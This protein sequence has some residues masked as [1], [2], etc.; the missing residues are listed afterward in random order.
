MKILN[1]FLVLSQLVG[2]AITAQAEKILVDGG[3]T[4][5]SSTNI[6]AY[7][8]SGGT[9][10][11]DGIFE[12]TVWPD[13]PDPPPLVGWQFIDSEVTC[14]FTT[15]VNIGSVVA[16]FADSDG[17]AGVSVPESIRLTTRGG[18]D[19][20]F[21]VVNPAGSGTTVPISIE[22]LDLTTDSITLFIALNTATDN[23]QCC[24]GSYEWIMMSE[25][26]FFTP[27]DPD[28]PLAILPAKV[29]V[30]I[31]NEPA[32]IIDRFTIENSSNV[33]ADLLIEGVTFTGPDGGR[34]AVTEFPSSLAP[35]A[36]GDV[37]FTV[38]TDGETG[39]FSA[40]AEIISNDPRS[41][42]SVGIEIVSREPDPTPTTPYQRAVVESGAILYWTFDEA[43]D[44][45][46][47]RSLVDNQIANEIVPQGSATRTD[48]TFT[49]GGVSLGR[50]ASFD[51]GAD[52]RFLAENLAR[53]APLGTYVIE[54][55]FIS[56]ITAD[57]YFSEMF[58][59]TNTPNQPGLIYNYNDGQLE[60]FNGSRTGA[61]ASPDT[62][63][64][65]VIAH[66]GPDDGVEI[67]LDNELQATLTET[68]AGSHAF[69]RF[70][71]GNTVQN[72]GGLVGAIDEYAI[73]DLDPLM[74]LEAKRAKVAEIAAHS[75]LAFKLEV[76]SLDLESGDMIKLVWR[77]QPGVVYTV[78]WS[79]NLTSFDGEI[80]NSI[81]SQGNLTE[82]SFKN[83]TM[84]PET[85]EGNEK[86][87]F[88]VSE[89][90]PN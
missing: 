15:E 82:F 79:Q 3:Y 40:M 4:A 32:T 28:V 64:H 46:S 85:P 87:F 71:I 36:S 52:S 27:P 61:S 25:V 34:L 81:T 72:D 17:S 51:G 7:E 21:P 73:Y 47:A 63:H 89:N 35:G 66:Y 41:P 6:P 9:E 23:G 74:E 39:V 19:Q 20:I 13:S 58:S 31:L 70:A 37:L 56:D 75:T 45:D 76:V 77:S 10:L 8:D 33:S 55:W 22:G 57:R 1:Q 11:T 78:S 42:Q 48:S 43:G 12:T 80:S 16:W 65:V 88:R 84:T 53:I 49:G 68:Y 83:P 30:S 86:L 59:E 14:N 50:S 60:I 67:Y 29:E 44:F 69:G 90:S 5:T 38:A 62:W 26:E 18:F 2:T 54:F 24:G